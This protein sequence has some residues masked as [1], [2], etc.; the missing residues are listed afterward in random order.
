MRPGPV[1][2]LREAVDPEAISVLVVLSQAP[3]GM[4]STAV[5]KAVTGVSDK[6]TGE[7]SRISKTLRVLVELAAV[8]VERRRAA[9]GEIIRHLHSITPLGRQLIDLYRNAD[10]M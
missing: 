1:R 4:T 10:P 2:P 5:T 9:P 3:V 7:R 6:H 8:S